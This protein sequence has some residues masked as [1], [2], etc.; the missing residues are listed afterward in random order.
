MVDANKLPKV[1]VV[2]VNGWRDDA[3]SNTLR[4]IFSC[5]DPERLA[6]VYTS[7]QMPNSDTCR[8]YFQICENQVLRVYLNLLCV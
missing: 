8:H 1:L 7:S 5:W 4:D 2:D 6:L 3:G